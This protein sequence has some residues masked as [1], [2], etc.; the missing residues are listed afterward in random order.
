MKESSSQPV[1]SKKQLVLL[2]GG[3]ANIQLLKSMAINPISGMRVCLISD[4]PYAPYS[5]M[6]P[7]LLS[8][9]Y[10]PE[11]CHFDLRRLSYLA[12][13]EF[14]CA[15]AQSM[16][17]NSARINFADRP[18]IAYDIL[19]INI[20]AT[21]LLPPSGLTSSLLPLKPIAEL[22]TRWNV[23]MK[24]IEKRFLAGLPAPKI[25]IVGGGAAGCEVAAALQERVAKYWKNFQLDL[26]HKGDQLLPSFPRHASRLGEKMLRDSSVRIIFSSPVSDVRDKHL[27]LTSGETF[28]YDWIIWALGVKPP[29]F[30]QESGLELDEQGFIKVDRYLRCID[31]DNVF[32]AGDVASFPISLKKAGVYAVRQGPILIKN[33][34]AVYRGSRLKKY[35]PQK[36]ILS[37]LRLGRGSI[38]FS[39]GLFSFS[40]PFL[41]NFKDRIDRNFMESWQNYKPGL[42]SLVISKRKLKLHESAKNRPNYGDFEQPLCGGCAAKISPSAVFNNQRGIENW[43]GI[44]AGDAGTF[45]VEKGL[46]L[47]ESIDVIKDLG[48]DLHTFGRIAALHSMC[49]LIVSGVKPRSAQALIQLKRA[50]DHLIKNDFEVIMNG[51]LCEL[52]NHQVK[53]TGG[54]SLIGQELFAGLSVCGFRTDSSNKD[55]LIQAGD[56]LVLSKPIGSGLLLAA[57]MQD[58]ASGMYVHAMIKELL[59]PQLLFFDL[60]QKGLIS[61]MTDISGFGLGIHG[62]R[63]LHRMAH[64]LRLGFRFDLKSIPYFNGVLDL[65]AK[66]VRS[67]LHQ[68]NFDYFYQNNTCEIAQQLRSPKPAHNTPALQVMFDPQTA[69]P[70]L[71]VVP[72]NAVNEVLLLLCENN[73][74]KAC[75]VGYVEQIKNNHYI[76]FDT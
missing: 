74:T 59:K 68:G 60:Y 55:I 12:G 15:K 48:V 47:A 1:P 13:A 18:P 4:V 62:L 24:S 36:S 3:H 71:A 50:A 35:N 58:L 52:D 28:A 70:I 45:E 51:I 31:K 16:N 49:D 43:G 75:Q 67:S 20:G 27:V 25:A 41:W 34:R 40:S 57:Q 14:I 56:A 46:H 63:L 61:A 7:G 76:S 22:L 5:G 53:L 9:G 42:K 33:I 2:G 64:N 72:S 21:P 54:H 39:K 66:G 37:L 44:V 32:C 19:S 73:L 29:A 65:V 26:W 38:I 69:G 17:P 6:L 11:Q 23:M 30:T 10:Q 8:G